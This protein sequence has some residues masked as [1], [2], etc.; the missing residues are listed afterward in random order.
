MRSWAARGELWLALVFVAVAVVWI[1]RA[2]TVLPLWDGFAPEAGFLPLIY[3]SLLALLAGVVFVHE[4]RRPAPPADN[5]RKPFIVVG[6]LALAVLAL[7][8]AHF[9]PSVFLLLLFLYAVVERLPLLPSVLASAGTT[10]TLYLVF[11][12]WLGV[13]LP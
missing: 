12:T 5:L 7:P 3:G 10:G 4:L 2:A 6:A 8:Y 9:A 13:P 11:R 1:V